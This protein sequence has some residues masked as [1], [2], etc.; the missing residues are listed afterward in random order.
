MVPVTWIG[1]AEWSNNNPISWVVVSPR[2]DYDRWLISLKARVRLRVMAWLGCIFSCYPMI[3]MLTPVLFGNHCNR[4]VVALMA[5]L[6]L[7]LMARFTSILFI[8]PIVSPIASLFPAVGVT[9]S[10]RFV[11]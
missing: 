2:I 7:T 6:M 3:C 8:D 1:V 10:L 4:W 11:T 5:I 9:A